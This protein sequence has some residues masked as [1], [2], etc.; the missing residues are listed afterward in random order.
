MSQI[1]ILKQKLV[2]QKSSVIS[3][4]LFYHAPLL[5]AHVSIQLRLHFQGLDYDVSM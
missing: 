2:Y 3:Y 5:T 1:C 4:S